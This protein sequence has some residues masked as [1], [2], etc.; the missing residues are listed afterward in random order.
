MV[1][2]TNNTSKFTHVS[3]KITITDKKCTSQEIQ[4]KFMFETTNFIFS[5]FSDNK[6]VFVTLKCL[7]VK[8]IKPL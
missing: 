7:F 1:I 8:K 2:F 3:P 5:R 6:M 4:S